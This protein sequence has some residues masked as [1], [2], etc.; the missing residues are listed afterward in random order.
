MV[1]KVHRPNC[2]TIRVFTIKFC[3]VGP[4]ELQMYLKQTLYNEHESSTQSWAEDKKQA[5]G[6]ILI[7]ISN[8]FVMFTF[9]WCVSV[10]L[11]TQIPQQSARQ[12]PIMYSYSLTVWAAVSLQLWVEKKKSK[13]ALPSAWKHKRR[14]GI[15]SH[16]PLP[17][18]TL[19]RGFCRPLN[20]VLTCPLYHV[21]C[22]HIHIQQ[23]PIACIRQTAVYTH[24]VDSLMWSAVQCWPLT[25]LQSSCFGCCFT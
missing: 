9:S 11:L 4:T 10:S 16:T 3:T 2:Q 23:Q 18:V 15:C 13:R 7:L 12:Q 25:A 5:W 22:M 8:W 21:H 24:I 14:R 19:P 6:K 20:G 1:R 17:T